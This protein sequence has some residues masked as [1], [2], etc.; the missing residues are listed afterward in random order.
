MPSPAEFRAAL[1]EL[2]RQAQAAGI[3]ADL[4]VLVSDL[5]RELLDPRRPGTR[6]LA[7]HVARLERLLATY[8]PGARAAAIQQRL[9]LSRSAYYRL[10]S[11]SPKWDSNLAQSSPRV[12]RDEDFPQ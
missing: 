12:L 6:E 9:G 8:E 7:A 11:P 10:R 3:D 1:A 4:L 5:A 2:I